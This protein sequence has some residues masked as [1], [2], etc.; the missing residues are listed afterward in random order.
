M[1]QSTGAGRERDVVHRAAETAPDGLHVVRSRVNQS[2]ARGAALD[3][4]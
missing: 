3:G 2:N 4:R 1:V